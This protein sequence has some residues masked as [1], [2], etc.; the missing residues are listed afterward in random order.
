MLKCG[1]KRFLSDHNDVPVIKPNSVYC[2]ADRHSLKMITLGLLLVNK[3]KESQGV[4]SV[5]QVIFQIWT[6][7]FQN[8]NWHV[9]E[10]LVQLSKIYFI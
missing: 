7:T 4:W 2:L 9:G 3:L 10:G 8:T 1:D 6:S 5:L